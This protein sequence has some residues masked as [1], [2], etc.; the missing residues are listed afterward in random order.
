MN[1][2]A[3]HYI[4]QFSNQW[5]LFSFYQDWK[6]LLPLDNNTISRKYDFISI[7]GIERTDIPRSERHSH[8]I[9]YQKTQ[10][11]DLVNALTSIASFPITQS[12]KVLSI[13]LLKKS[14]SFLEAFDK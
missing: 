3:S 12:K 11:Y 5:I 2:E 4:V 7:P 14:M 6:L 8:L 9:Y 1:F 13:C 10:R